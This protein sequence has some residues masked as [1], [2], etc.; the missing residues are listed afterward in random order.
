M[1]FAAER[2]TF[3]KTINQHQAIQLRLADMAT[4][5]VAARQMTQL[6]AIE[7]ERGNRSDMLSAMAKLFASEACAEIAQD[8]L[9]IHGGHGYIAD[10]QVERFLREAQL[11]LVGEGTSDIQK[12]VISRRMQEGGE[13][14]ILGLA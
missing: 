4:R 1:R 12:L 8:A 3:G 7:K 14:G 11:Y 2:K 9:R 6:A 5:L 13:A 10:Y